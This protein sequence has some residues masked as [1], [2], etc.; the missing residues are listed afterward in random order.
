MPRSE[1]HPFAGVW[2]GAMTLVTESGDGLKVPRLLV[3]DVADSVRG[4][5]TGATILP[6]NARA[7]HVETVVAKGEMHWKQPNSGGG[8]WVYAV[9]LVA[10]DSLAG[11]V[12]LEDWPQLTPGQKPPSGTISLVRRQPGR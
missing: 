11:T 1:R 2:D 3:I 12:A 5:Y 6:D 9:R 10:R 8:F 7:P 4:T